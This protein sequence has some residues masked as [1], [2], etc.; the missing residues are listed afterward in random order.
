MVKTR[1]FAVEL[2]AQIALA[3]AIGTFVAVVLAGV[4]MLLAA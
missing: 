2:A 3:A 4:T 1:I